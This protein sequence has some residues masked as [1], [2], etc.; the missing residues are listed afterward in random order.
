MHIPVLKKEVLEY[1]DP[2]PDENFV[3]CTVGE[4]GHAKEL[5]EKIKPDGKVLG[6]DLDSKMIERIKK[7]DRLILVCGNYAD[8]DKIVKDRDFYPI[9][10]I[11]IDLGMSSWHV[12]DSKRGFTFLKDEPLDMRYGNASLSA[13]EIINEY[14]EEEL[15]SILRNYGEERFSKRIAEEIGRQRKIRPI[16][17]TLELVEAIKKAIPLKFQKINPAT[18]VFQAIR[19]AVNGELKNLEEFLPKAID[20]LAPSGRLAV[21]TFHSLEDRIVKNFFK[22]RSD[23]NILTKKPIA[24]GKEEIKDNPRS[25]SAKLRVIEKTI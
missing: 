9:N 24:P 23:I 14:D 22:N 3:D 18:R 13:Q 1:L 15:E 10:G 11:L 19:I 8:L 21:I 16:K 6:I 4:A 12:D 25:R 20:V 5:L 2:K 7:H 17:T